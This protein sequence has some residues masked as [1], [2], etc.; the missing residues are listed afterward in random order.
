MHRIAPNEQNPHPACHLS[1][2][3]STASTATV[4]VVP[5]P[6][7]PKPVIASKRSA[8]QEPVSSNSD[9]E[10]NTPKLKKK[11]AAA[12]EPTVPEP[13]PDDGLGRCQWAASTR[14]PLLQKYHDTEWC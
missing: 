1:S 13:L 2:L 10:S 8:R 9:T 5:I 7:T 4:S 3:P 11:R 6:S 14:Y 12:K